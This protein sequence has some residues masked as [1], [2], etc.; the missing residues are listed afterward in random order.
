M[1]AILFTD[2]SASITGTEY[3]LASNSTSQTPQ[4]N[5]CELTVVLDFV[6][7]IAGDQYRIR[8]YERVDGGTGAQQVIYESTVT[9]V[10]AQL[11]VLPPLV[12][13]DNWEVSL[14]RIS[15][16][17]RTIQ[18]S[19]R[20]VNAD[21]ASSVN[22]ASF[23]ANA[24][25]A[26]ALKA[27]AVTEIQTGLALAATALSTAQWTNGRAALLDHLTADVATAAAL[28][29]AQTAVTAI[30]A[31]T[32]NLPSDPADESL[33]IAATN[34]ILAAIAALPSASTAAA[35]VW[36]AIGEASNQGSHTYG[37]IVRLIASLLGGTVVSFTAGTLVFKS[38]NGLKTRATI[39]IDLVNKTGRLTLVIGDLT[40]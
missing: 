25:D 10:Q 14:K 2:G 16:S 30:K 17:S 32:D 24:I 23:T 27:D 26:N 9:G 40:P 4:T 3:F 22:V 28:A 36:A 31:S 21:A 38:L 12:V 5:K 18:W 11:V 33:I 35:A 34:S 1:A 19:L 7:M 8:I 20:Q 29:T 15:A 6:N 37:D 13:G 39:T